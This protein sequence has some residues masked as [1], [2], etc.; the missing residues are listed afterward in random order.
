[1]FFLGSVHLRDFGML[2]WMDRQ[3]FLTRE[4]WRWFWVWVWVGQDGANGLG[5]RGDGDGCVHFGCFWGA[6]GRNRGEVEES[7]GVGDA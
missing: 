7:G 4:Y 6:L 2:R 1:M 3:R 5:E